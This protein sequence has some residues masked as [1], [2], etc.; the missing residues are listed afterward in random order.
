MA[1][2]TQ[3]LKGLLEGCILKII[4][5][6]ETYGYAICEELNRFGF[7]ELNEGTVYPI[8]IRLEKN[9]LIYSVKK[10][11][12][13]GPKRKYFYLTNEGE[14]QLKSFLINWKR[15]QSR[16]NRIVEEDHDE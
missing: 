16:V 15:M 14:N 13:L 12:P 2:N 11:S 10:D 8:L 6:K 5:K 7:N 9:N 3:M 4:S 1:D